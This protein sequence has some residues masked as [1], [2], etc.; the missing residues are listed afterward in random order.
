[1]PIDVRQ[2]QLVY[3]SKAK[4][5]RYVIENYKMS[6]KMYYTLYCRV[7]KELK[8]KCR[9]EPANTYVVRIFNVPT[10]AFWMCNKNTNLIFTKSNSEHVTALHFWQSFRL[11]LNQRRE[12]IFLQHA[13]CSVHQPFLSEFRC[14]SPVANYAKIK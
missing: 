12:I 4:C 1:M 6:R 8:I 10:H 2:A 14:L 13:K 3:I 11:D 7:Q 9:R 5:K